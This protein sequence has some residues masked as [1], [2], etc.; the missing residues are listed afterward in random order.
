MKGNFNKTSANK[1][2][3]T[4]SSTCQDVLVSDLHIDMNEKLKG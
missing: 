1:V 3:G 2:L 4:G